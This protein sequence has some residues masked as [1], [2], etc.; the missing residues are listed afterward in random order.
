M[1]HKKNK[2]VIPLSN[3]SIKKALLGASIIVGGFGLMGNINAVYA[4]TEAIGTEI[5]D[6]N[7]AQDEE[8]DTTNETND[9]VASSDEATPATNDK[10]TD[11]NADKALPKDEIVEPAEPVEENPQVGPEVQ[12]VAYGTEATEVAP[13]AI[14]ESTEPN[15]G[16]DEKNIKDFSESERYRST[17]MEQGDGTAANYKPPDEMD[18][19][20]D[21]YRYHS[22]EPSAT[23][24]DKTQW[25]IEIE[26]DK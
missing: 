16:E 3:E 13:T 20:I 17:Q 2:F 18:N 25:G 10:T 23:S 8:S 21:G 24:E 4:D 11:A 6:N 22:S 15:Y 19:F 12:A 5:V 7:Q 14:P 1:N 9:E 26:I